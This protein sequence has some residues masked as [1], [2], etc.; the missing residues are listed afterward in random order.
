MFCDF[1]CYRCVVEDPVSRLGG[2]APTNLFA[3][4]QRH[5]ETK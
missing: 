3:A 4:S 2:G 1:A 5:G